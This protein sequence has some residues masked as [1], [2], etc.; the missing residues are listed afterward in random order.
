MIRMIW[1]FLHFWKI[2]FWFFSFPSWPTTD[3]LLLMTVVKL[4]KTCHSQR[5]AII[6]LQLLN[7][8]IVKNIR[9]Y[10]FDTKFIWRLSISFLTSSSSKFWTFFTLLNDLRCIR[11][12]EKKRAPEHFESFMIAV[13]LLRRLSF[14]A[15]LLADRE[16]RRAL[17]GWSVLGEFQW[18]HPL[19][20]FVFLVKKIEP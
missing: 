8:D 19:P 6:F 4:L 5:P 3:R 12:E 13:K 16:K 2:D 20:H 17:I 15:V 7:S 1:I 10:I 18:P 11:I 9:S 14:A